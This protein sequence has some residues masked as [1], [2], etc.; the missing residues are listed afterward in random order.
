MATLTVNGRQVTVDDSF[1]KLSPEQQEATVNEIAASLPSPGAPAPQQPSTGSAAGAYAA[2]IGKAGAAGLARGTADVLGLPGTIGDLMRSGVDLGLS[3]GYEAIMGAPPRADGGALER[4]FAPLQQQPSRVSGQG[5]RDLASSATGGATDFKG[6]T[7]PGQFAGTIG[8]FV[9]GAAAF[10]G[11][12][13]GTIGRFGVLP[14]IGSEAAGQATQGTALEPFA[15]IGGAMLAPAAP[16]ALQ[17]ISSPFAGA[18]DP[19]RQA[20]IQTLEQ[21]GVPITAGQRVGSDGLKRAESM[22]GGGALDRAMANQGEAFTSAAMQRAGG[23]GLATPENMTR[24]DQ[25][26]GAGFENVSARNTMAVDMQLVDDL[27]VSVQKYGRLLDSQQRSIISNLAD[28]VI[29]RA[30]SG[31]GK[32]P[33]ADYQAIRS[34]LGAA[35]K[36]S[37]N[38]YLARAFKGIQRSLDDAMVRSVSPEDASE[39]ARLRSQYGNFKV[40][41]RAAS[42]AGADAAFGVISPAKLRQAAST[43]RQGSY[44]QGR[45]DLDELARAGVAVLGRP[46]TSGTAEN[47]RA[48]GIASALLAGGGG[49]AGGIPGAVAGVAAPWAAGAAMMSRPGQA[50]LANQA[51]DARSLMDPN[52]AAVIQA[53][54]SQNAGN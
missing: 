33:G 39:W 42:G 34:E 1:L 16:W 26:I 43:G 20:A 2:D 24:I 27:G 29:D 21:A 47:A 7:I 35:A 23:Q 15:R 30:V 12:N 3:Q 22:L 18:I 52:Y 6:Q 28:D 49:A 36:G 11:G 50:Y 46:S 45:G 41:E 31:G 48:M 38:T 14:G 5:L 25:R 10:G 4:F 54:I 32:I 9:P 37:S 44:V 40:L 19:A 53:L 13:L 17:K 8:E 51:M